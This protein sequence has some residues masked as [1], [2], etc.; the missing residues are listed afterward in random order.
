MIV[1][2]IL[3]AI[4][5]SIDGITAGVIANSS[6]LKI[7]SIHL[8]MSDQ[9]EI[10][11]ITLV[12]E[13]TLNGLSVESEIIKSLRH[14]CEETG[15]FYL[16]IDPSELPPQL[17]SSVF[18]QSKKFF[19]LPTHIKEG[20]SDMEL[21][22][23]YTKMGE[24][25]LDP[26]NQIV[27]DTKEGFYI[28]N[29]FPED[30]PMFNPA[31]LRGPNVWP[32]KELINDNSII[33]C[34]YGSDKINCSLWKDVMNEYHEKLTSFSIRLVR[35]IALSIGLEKD[36]FDKEFDPPIAMMR[37]VHYSKQKSDPERGVLACGAHTDWGMVRYQNELYNKK[38]SIAVLF[39]TL[40][41]SIF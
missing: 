9:F 26:S 38:W 8:K 3:V 31:K 13:S 23:G 14:A 18:A 2:L 28:S 17:V 6:F 40:L 34:R 19:D 16:K 37:L 21:N 33:C 11:T 29:D 10:P 12:D 41:F 24:Q 7:N 1:Y 4:L 27:G 36:Y 22:R 25:T 35:M 5:S 39:L 32:V 20:V 30:S 15:F